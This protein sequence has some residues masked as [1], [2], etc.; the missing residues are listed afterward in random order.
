MT[1][2]RTLILVMMKGE[3]LQIQKIVVL[4]VVNLLKTKLM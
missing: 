3:I 1:M 2:V 4:V